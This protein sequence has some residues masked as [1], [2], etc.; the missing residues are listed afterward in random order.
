M[1]TNWLLPDNEEKLAKAVIS[2]TSIAEVCR[3]LGLAPR[4]GNYKT[5]KHHITR[6]KLGTDHHLGQ[7]WSRGNYA[8]PSANRHKTTIKQHLIRTNG[9][10]CEQCGTVEWQGQPVP[11]EMDHI[12]GMNN[13]NRLE[14]LRILCCNCHALTP[15]FRNK[16]R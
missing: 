9:H 5:I 4:G 3:V 11:L 13:D 16:K 1:Y 2:S 15:T 10:R 6:L 12:N 7:A 14:N 8:S